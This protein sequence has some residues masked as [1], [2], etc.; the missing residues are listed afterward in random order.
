MAKKD[1]K[2]TNPAM[3]FISAESIE[4]VDGKNTT[5]PTGEVQAPA[6]Y[7]VAPKTAEI[8]SRRVQI[9]LQP[10]LYDAVKAKATEEGISFNEAVS[11]ALKKYIK[12]RK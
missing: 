11:T 2:N 1:F 3:S 4:A 10:T 7:R 9:L 6:G 5:T 12:K 8:K